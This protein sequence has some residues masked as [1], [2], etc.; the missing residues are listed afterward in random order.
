MN[1]H[2]Y[3]IHGLVRGSRLELGRDVDTG[4]Q[5]RYVVEFAKALSRRPE[6]D[7]VELFTRRIT[8][9]CVSRTYGEQMLKH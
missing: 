9:S 4:G 1:I 8:D 2:L 7:R 3:S 6:V 5:T